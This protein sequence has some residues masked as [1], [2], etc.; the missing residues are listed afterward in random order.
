MEASGEILGCI[1]NIRYY[2]G[3]INKLCQ[4]QIEL[5]FRRF[6]MSEPDG[7]TRLTVLGIISGDLA[8]VENWLTN[9]EMNLGN[10]DMLEPPR[11]ELLQE[12]LL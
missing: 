3:E 6:E 2:S 7:T 1:K 4:K 11:K 9:I 12:S 8:Q 10:V 5:D